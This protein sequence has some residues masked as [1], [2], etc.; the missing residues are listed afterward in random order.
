MKSL[1]LFLLFTVL[2]G[3]V[4]PLL[5]MGLAQVIFYN[6]ANGHLVVQEG[7][8]RGSLLI[9]QKFSQDKYFWPR[10]SATDYNPL[11]SGGSNLGPISRSLKKQ[12]EGRRSRF[13][14]EKVPSEMLYASGSGLDPHLSHEGALF[15]VE[16][17]SKSRGIDKE[18]II[19]KILSHP[20]V[21]VLEINL[22]LD[23]I[24]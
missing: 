16:R 2:S 9:A 3:F 15:Q 21:N 6:Q 8:L 5:V 4:Y 12:V 11:P 24:K 17:V 10:P 20:L 18:K 23:E 1:R 22:W 14:E 19:Q 7:T 13:S